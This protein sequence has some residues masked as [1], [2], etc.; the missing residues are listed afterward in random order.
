M[1]GTLDGYQDAF[2]TDPARFIITQSLR[3]M[4]EWPNSQ[5]IIDVLCSAAQLHQIVTLSLCP[6]PASLMLGLIFIIRALG[7]FVYFGTILL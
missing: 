4:R 3:A 6:F 1:L 5:W 7:S 2:A